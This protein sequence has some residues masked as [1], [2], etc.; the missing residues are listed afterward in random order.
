MLSA[1]TAEAQLV[2]GRVAE[3]VRHCTAVHDARIGHMLQV[4]D[5]LNGKDYAIQRTNSCNAFPEH[6][7]SSDV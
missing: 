7:V 3:Q 1:G 4:G 6:S 2:G 5:P